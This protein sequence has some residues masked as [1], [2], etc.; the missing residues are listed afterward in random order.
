MEPLPE[1]A[2]E[3][4]QRKLALGRVVQT[5]CNLLPELAA[6]VASYIVWDIRC[7]R[8][9]DVIEARDREEE[10]YLA[11]ITEIQ[12]LAV[13]VHFFGWS[14]RYN[15]WISQ[16]CGRF[17]VANPFAYYHREPNSKCSNSDDCRCLI[18]TMIREQADLC[19]F[20][21][22]LSLK[23]DDQIVVDHRPAIV[24]TVVQTMVTGEYVYQVKFPDGSI[25]TY[26][27][28]CCLCSVCRIKISSPLPN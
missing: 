10:W 1:Q 19:F 15:E 7:L 6:I 13:H 27:N 12:P 20:C 23:V 25:F 24:Q 9:G 18:R 16:L 2:A 14:S 3:T 11:T 5:A 28:S 4:A 8:V 17:I 22:T 26:S 21:R